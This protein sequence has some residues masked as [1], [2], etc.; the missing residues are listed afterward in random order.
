MGKKWWY[1]C[2]LQ[3][4]VLIVIFCLTQY[5]LAAPLKTKAAKKGKPG[6]AA[7]SQKSQPTRSDAAYSH[8]KTAKAGKQRQTTA[9]EKPSY[10]A[11]KVANA[12]STTKSP[13]SRPLTKAARSTV[14]GKNKRPADS[15]TQATFAQVKQ[16]DRNRPRVAKA[17]TPKQGHKGQNPR[18]RSAKGGRVLALKETKDHKY[19]KT[20]VTIPSPHT[21][22]RAKSSRSASSLQLPQ[23]PAAQALATKPTPSEAPLAV[24]GATSQ[25]TLFESSPPIH[26]LESE[27]PVAS[28]PPSLP[29]MPPADQPFSVPATPSA[30][31]SPIVLIDPPQELA[32]SPEPSFAGPKKPEPLVTTEPEWPKSRPGYAPERAAFTVKFNGERLHYRLNSAFVL[33][34][35]EIF[36]EVV[37]AQRRHDYTYRTTLG[38]ERQL[39]ATRWYWHAPSGPGIYPVRV[40]RTRSNETVTLNVFVMVPLD[41]V[42]GGFLNGYRIGYYPAVALRQQPI[43]TP[44]RG[45]IEVTLENEN[46]LVSPHFR[47]RQ[48]LCKQE[49]GYPKYMVLDGRLLTALELLLEKANAHGYQARTLTVMSGYRTPYY[50][51]AIGNSTTY[52]R[53][54]WGDAAD[55]FI[56]ENPEDGRMDDLNQDGEVD[57]H[58]AGVLYDL[59]ESGYES[60][61]RSL[62]VGG[63]ARYRETSSHGPFVHVDVRGVAARW[64]AG[65]TAKGIVPSTVPIV[66]RGGDAAYLPQPSYWDSE[67]ETDSAP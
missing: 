34:G 8:T 13:K 30:L 29:V 16:T 47:L 65:R 6:A 11:K 7:K 32:V 2:G 52:S 24:T 20:V 31:S 46:T 1:R 39:G 33:P 10:P 18:V 63:L 3:T 62:L 49:G 44:P 36:V 15:K 12:S 41:R 59:I 45:L 51:R 58:D 26:L 43:Y 57:S 64:G 67:S 42:E 55:I 4:Q 66:L 17:S 21:A 5:A 40:Q 25:P 54:V 60:R 28:A 9:R 27:S 38:K 19:V 37:D 14:L 35:D 56:D 48:F 53:H 23:K 22:S 61:F 50:N